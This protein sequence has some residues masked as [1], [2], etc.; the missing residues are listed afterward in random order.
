LDQG[1]SR[2]LILISAP[3]G[4]GK[5]TLLSHWIHQS[6]FP[7]AWISLDGGDNDP[8]SF[9]SYLITALQSI[10]SDIGRAALSMLRSPQPP[11]MESVLIN[12]L[13]E[14]LSVSDDFALVLDDYHV[15]DAPAIHGLLAFILE[16]CPSRLHLVIATRSDPDLPLAR[17]RSQR[18]L[19]EIR[20][21]DLIFNKGETT[22]F[23]KAML[24][25]D[26]S[27]Q[28]ITILESRTEGWVAGL[29][30]IALLLQ[31]R[32]D[33]SSIIQDF[34]SQHRYIGDYLIEEVLNRQSEPIQDF[35]LTTS[36]LDRLTAPLCDAVT[37]RSDSREVLES[38][39]R[40]NLFLFPLDDERR[41]FRYHQ[42]F[43]D[44]LQQRLCRRQPAQVSRLHLRASDWYARNLL[45]PD[46]VEHALAAQE[47]ERAAQ[48]IEEIGEIVWDYGLQSRQLEWLTRFPEPQLTA[49]PQL[50]VFYAVALVGKGEY[51]AAQDRLERTERTLDQLSGLD[52]LVRP[53]GTCLKVKPLRRLLRGRIDTIYAL[54]ATIKGDAAQIDTY[55]QA[56]LENL[57]A[58]DWKWRCMAA[59]TSGMAHGWTGDGQLI[60]AQKRFAE[61]TE[62]SRRAGNTHLEIFSRLCEAS[63]TGLRGRPD[64]AEPDLR[65]LLHAAE[66][67]GLGQ[68]GLAGSIHAAL[69]GI[70]CEFDQVEEGMQE[71]DQGIRLTRA[72]HDWMWQA[73]AHFNRVHACRLI[74]DFQGIQVGLEAIERLARDLHIPPWIQHAKS[75]YQ[76]LVWITQGDRDRVR[77][78]IEE[79]R[80]KPDDSVAF[81]R[82]PE[83]QVLA[84]ILSRTG[85]PDDAH[86]LFRRLI[87]PMK[88]HD[89]IA[90]LIQTELLLAISL[91]VHGSASEAAV[92]MQKALE[93]AA[94]GGYVRTFVCRGTPAA[95]LL[96]LVFSQ[97]PAGRTEKEK[98]GFSRAYVRKLLAAFKAD[99]P[100]PQPAVE[101]WEALSEREMEV[102]SLIAAGLSNQRIAD[103]LFISLNTVRTHT[104]NINSK[105]GVHSRTQAVAKAKQKGLIP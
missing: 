58:D 86:R 91:W 40:N 13:N 7:A 87:K 85:S 56:A 43:A 75:A 12:L 97:K 49:W 32:N 3:A 98:P 1:L 57:R 21:R 17:L 25:L 95:E 28:D 9:L 94:P 34:K 62:S 8:V 61:S 4:F 19:V 90:M 64:L 59:V 52:T 48:L 77:S 36:I 38:L 5:T 66:E 105:L 30:L 92:E 44:L 39:E 104:K 80:L 88:S 63:V 76:A 22:Q 16:H 60:L 27:A 15:V 93:L 6:G 24:N 42:L 81:W 18:Q 51:Q 31:D 45:G 100:P 89:R 29:Q 46:A 83:Y 11:G 41:W 14:I 10:K 55:S 82:E 47:Y 99:A 73:A 37:Q 103:K 23:F 2:R 102:L 70:L 74:G 50:G 79:R 35:L 101:P 67:K 78:W 53:D 68:T 54:L 65:R 96:E 72:N 69:G 84:W 20:S 71:I 33:V 26:L